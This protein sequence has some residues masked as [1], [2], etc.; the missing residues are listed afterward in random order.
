M[1]SAPLRICFLTY[2]GNPHCGGQG[3][4]TR[5]L[6][7][8]LAALGHAVDVWSGPPYPSLDDGVGLQRLPSLDL[9]NAQALFRRPS[10]AELRDPI[11]RSEW[12]ATLTGAF[13]EPITFTRRAA[14]RYRQLPPSQRYDVIH[15][16]QS[17]GDGLLELR[18]YA[19]VIATI[20][21]PITVDRDIAL[22]AAPSWA[23]R[24]GV[25]RWYSFIPRQLQV[26]AQLDCITTVSRA[27]A[28]DIVRDFGIARGA[29]RVVE[30]GVDL[31]VFRPQPEVVRRADVL[32]CVISATA[33]LK[34]FRYL[35][36]AFAELRRRRPQL[37]LKVVGS[38]GRTATRRRIRELGLEGAVQFTGPLSD[39][40][41]AGAYAEATLAV[42]PSLYEGF[43]LPA[44][45]AMACE[46]PVVSTRAGALP[47]VVGPDGHAGVLVPPAESEALA[48]SIAALLD[49]PERR[50]AMGA[51][52]RRRVQDLF[53]WRRAAERMTEVYGELVA[54]RPKAAAC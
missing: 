12:F 25:R 46:V 43:G 33:P 11:N 19:P 48:R 15:D 21:H 45:E 28:S 10:L 8:E 14:R 44:A 30:N 20:H 32:I 23:K 40:E 39:R 16:N 22:A 41:I 50:R 42:V 27:S 24:A 5:H 2:R 18:N 51:A 53:A 29:I 26:A 35:L 52:G 6:T 47:E 13:P 36:E 38:D 49:A 37:I 7:R 34:G 54:A 3:V 31:G 1:S 4:Y 17:L 9:W